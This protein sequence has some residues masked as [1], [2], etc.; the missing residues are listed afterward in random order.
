M[1][2]RTSAEFCGRVI[3]PDRYQ[4]YWWE[5]EREMYRKGETEH[6]LYHFLTNYCATPEESFQHSTGS[7]LPPET[8]EFMRTSAHPGMPYHVEYGSGAAGTVPSSGPSTSTFPVMYSIGYA[9]ALHRMDPAEYDGDPRGILWLWEAPNRTETYFMG[10]DVA[11]GRTGWN[12]YARFKGD[13][14]TDNGAII[15]IRK[16]R[17]GAPDYQ[18]AEYA[19]PVDPFDLGEIANLAGR[20]YSG[21]DEDQCRCIIEVQPGPGFGTLQRMMELGYMNHFRWE[22]YADTA[23]TTA[24]HGLGWHA[25]NRSNRD[26]WV[27]ASRHVNLRQFISRSPWLTEEY[28]DCRMNPDKGYAENTS[29]HDDRVRAANLAIWCARGWSMNVERTEER[30]TRGTRPVDLQRTDMS[31]QAIMEEWSKMLDVV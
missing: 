4:L 12:R 31:L 14:K 23:V 22:Y 18:V 3:R 2:E 8:L 5:T 9:G 27:K 25:S 16:G 29:G 1:I 13:A 15:V 6:T 20:L 10:I 11:N 28:A 24:N 17:N 26:L 21:V 7:A 19:A 30:V